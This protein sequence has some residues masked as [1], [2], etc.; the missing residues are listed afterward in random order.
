MADQITETGFK[1]VVGI[2]GCGTMGLPMAER[3]HA[4][5][6]EVWGHDVR[7]TDDFG[8]FA[9]RMLMDAGEFARRCDVVISV[10][11]D[12][13]QTRDLLFGEQGLATRD[14]RPSTLVVSSTV[15]PRFIRELAAELPNDMA[16][17]D[18]PMS[19]A[20]YRA[21]TGELSFMLG[22]PSD[23]VE[24]LMPLFQ[25][26][27]SE[28]FRMGD[29]SMGMTTKVLNNYCAAASVVATRRVMKMAES[30]DLDKR[31]LLAVMKQS[32]GS[33]WFAN[34]IDLIDWSKEGY[35]KTNTMGIVEK[36]VNS[37]LDAISKSDDLESWPLDEA[38]L[39]ALRRI[40][41]LD[42]PEDGSA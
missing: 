32:S 16:F 6:F 29:V 39:D 30:L 26:M 42:L 28:H 22:G 8:E 2:A 9:E 23:V 12:V 34:N 18:A 35:D 5:G 19:G 24:A 41:P 14:E 40:E 27:G 3:L 4:A 31:S 7:P 11:R 36:D 13:Q 37:A 21:R 15:S 10:V 33:N 1:G 17:M 25:E 38:I 20:P